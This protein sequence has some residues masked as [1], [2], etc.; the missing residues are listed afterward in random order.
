MEIMEKVNK[1][2]EMNKAY[3]VAIDFKKEKVLCCKEIEGF[4]EYTQYIVWSFNS[5]DG[6]TFWG[7]YFTDEA[8]ARKLFTK[9]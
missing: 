8:E 1:K 7:H 4:S 9:E 3:I 2:V 5:V 6:N